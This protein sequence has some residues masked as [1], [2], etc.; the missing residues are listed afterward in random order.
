MHT[1]IEFN[2]RILQK[3]YNDAGD[4]HFLEDKNASMKNL[5]WVYQKRG[6]KCPWWKSSEVKQ[7]SQRPNEG[8]SLG[9]WR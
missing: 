9:L 7:K 6:R 2:S 5:G 3:A 4:D 8:N 1:G